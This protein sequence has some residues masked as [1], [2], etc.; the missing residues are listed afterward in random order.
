VSLPINIVDSATGY[1]ATIDVG[2]GISVNPPQFSESYNATLDVDDTP[3]EIV[4]PL[5]D[6]I[7]CITGIIL[8]GNKNISTT[9]DAVVDIYEA[10]ATDTSTAVN[11]ILSIPVARSGQLVLPNMYLCSGEGVHIMGKTSDDDV[12]VTILGYYV[13][14]HT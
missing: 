1:T 10:L 9:V 2:G 6:N 14:Q 3:V 12:F 7:F 5:G 4:P 8:V 11:T 13:K